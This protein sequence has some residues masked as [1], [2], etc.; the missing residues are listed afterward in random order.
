[1]ASYNLR[2]ASGYSSRFNK[3]MWKRRNNGGSEEQVCFIAFWSASK[4]FWM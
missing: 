2:K 4:H 1:M 3:K